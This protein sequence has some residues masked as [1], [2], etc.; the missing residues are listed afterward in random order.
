MLTVGAITTQGVLDFSMEE[1]DVARAMIEQANQITVLADASKLN[2]AG[3]FQVCPLSTINRLVIDR[4]AR[5][6]VDAALREA[7]VDI[8]VAEDTDTERAGVTESR[9]RRRSGSAT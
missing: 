1:T 2:R 6:P 9:R 8:V 3:L 7:E 4:Q 5:T